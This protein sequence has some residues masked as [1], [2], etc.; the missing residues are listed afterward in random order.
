MSMI[1]P[2]MQGAQR[3]GLPGSLTADDEVIEAAAAGA[4]R[5]TALVADEGAHLAGV[6]GRTVG[7]EQADDHRHVAGIE[8]EFHG[9]EDAQ[10]VLLSGAARCCH[11]CLCR[12]RRCR[13]IEERLPGAVVGEVEVAVSALQGFQAALPAVG[14]VD[15]HGGLA[16]HD[17]ARLRV[18]GCQRLV[19]G[20]RRQRRVGYPVPALRE[21]DGAFCVL[22]QLSAR[23]GEQA[24]RGLLFVVGRRSIF[25]LYISLAFAA[26]SVPSPHSAPL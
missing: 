15:G 19:D 23:D 11:A 6:D 24:V 17:V 21:R 2:S 5:A 10:L 26:R 20:H 14:A 7:R 12:C 1:W 9:V 4:G 16:L 3:H 22:L 18:G 25:S 8:A 13:R